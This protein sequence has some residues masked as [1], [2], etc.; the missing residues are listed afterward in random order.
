MPRTLDEIRRIAMPLTVGS[1]I[2][3]LIGIVPGT[4]G[5]ISCFLAY[6]VSKRL[7]RNSDEYGT[8]IIEGIAAPES[9]NNATTGG[10]RYTSMRIS[11][12]NATI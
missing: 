6:D 10:A 3:L 12:N 7:S 5:A 4:G 1:V 8:G 11:K 2:G 9:S